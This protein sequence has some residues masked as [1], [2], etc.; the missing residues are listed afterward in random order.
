MMDILKKWNLGAELV[1]I[2]DPKE[3]LIEAK[4]CVEEHLSKLMEEQLDV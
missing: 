2:E 3:W 4:K 1:P